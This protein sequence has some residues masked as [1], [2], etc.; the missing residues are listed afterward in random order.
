M[1]PKETV[2]SGAEHPGTKLEIMQSNAGFYLGFAD[3]DGMPYSRETNYFGDAASALLVLRVF[4][5]AGE[6]QE[7]QEANYL[8]ALERGDCEYL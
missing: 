7:E 3:K 4:R 2:L 6:T 1:F 5:T 8:D